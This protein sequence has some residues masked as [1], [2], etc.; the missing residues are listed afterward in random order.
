MSGS[1][2]SLRAAISLLVIV[3]LVATAKPVAAAETDPPFTTATPSGTLGSNGWYRASP[4]TVA[5]AAIDNGSGVDTTYR[6]IGANPFVAGNAISVTTDGTNVVQYYSTDR[7]GNVETTRSLTVR[8][9]TR[10]P[11]AI[12]TNPPGAVIDPASPTVRRYS[13]GVSIAVSYQDFPGGSG[14]SNRSYFLT[15]DG[16]VGAWTAYTDPV[17]VSGEGTY[18]FTAVAIDVAGREGRA[19]LQFAIDTTPPAL[20]LAAIPAVAAGAMPLRLAASETLAAS[21]APSADLDGPGCAPCTVTFERATKFTWVAVFEA[22]AAGTYAVDV[23]AK[24]ITGNAGTLS[25]TLVAAPTGPADTGL[26]P[27]PGSILAARPASV[28]ATFATPVVARAVL[29]DGGFGLLTTAP[30]ATTATATL[31]HQGP[32]PHVA[33]LSVVDGA[34]AR[35]VATNYLVAPQAPMLSGLGVPD[36]VPANA[37][38]RAYVNASAEGAGLASVTIAGAPARWLRDTLWVADVGPVAEGATIEFDV[39]AT[40]LAGVTAIL[41]GPVRTAGAPGAGVAPGVEPGALAWDGRHLRANGASGPTGAGALDGRALVAPEGGAAAWVTGVATANGGRT[42]V[43]FDLDAFGP[44]LLRVR[45]LWINDT[46]A[47]LAAVFAPFTVLRAATTAPT[48]VD[49]TLPA[50]ATQGLVRVTANVSGA[51][52]ARLVWNLTDP[53]AGAPADARF[54]EPSTVSSAGGILSV[55]FDL[56]LTPGLLWARLEAH[57]ARNGRLLTPAKA[58]HV[59]DSQAPALFAPQPASGRIVD[60]KRPVIGLSWADPSGV[61][62]ASVVVQVNGQT[63]PATS[64]TL[65]GGGFTHV[66]AA[67]LDGSV[68]VSVDVKDAFGRLAHFDWTFT[69]GNAP[70]STTNLGLPAPC[71]AQDQVGTGSEVSCPGAAGSDATNTTGGAFETEPPAILAHGPVG[72]VRDAAPSLTLRYRDAASAIPATGVL[73]DLDGRRIAV[74]ATNESA[75]AT[76]AGL[77]P[78]PHRLEATVDDARGNRARLAWTFWYAPPGAAFDAAGGALTVPGVGVLDPRGAGNATVVVETRDGAL[79]LA[80]FADGGLA[81]VRVVSAEPFLLGPK[82]LVAGADLALPAIVRGNAAAPTLAFETPSPIAGSLRARVTGHGLAPLEV[83]VALVG[84]PSNWPTG[85]GIAVVGVDG[86]ATVY[87]VDLK[88]LPEGAWIALATVHDAWGRAA[89]A[90]ATFAWDETRPVASFSYKP[91]A[92]A[93]DVLARDAGGIRSVRLL[94]N[95]VERVN[96]TFDARENGSRVVTVPLEGPLP[97][98]NH[99]VVVETTDFAGNLARTEG[100]IDL[101]ASVDVPTQ[102]IPAPSLLAIVSLLGVAALL[103]RRR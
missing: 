16:V 21:P 81:S 85:P 87:D 7:D 14:I 69:V 6:R 56:Q 93:F 72:V 13:A 50:S 32:G 99:S 2:R 61:D 102:R 33:G 63:V 9:D 65:T 15:K 94:L 98:G 43:V 34:H 5:F 66:P 11:R 29:L 71:A 51:D 37:R 18:T 59:T 90:N 39:Q 74:S 12:I 76:L 49:L 77:A 40:T 73:V 58:L 83:R 25:T 48:L 52:R 38:V 100:W 27:A 80:G 26:T 3:G 47:D 44:G 31:G 88:G 54:A 42:D 79:H 67:D 95:G 36:A 75:T 30:A 4:V 91:G 20:S 96:A 41:D 28:T 78:G 17:A 23:E 92:T 10:D 24:D 57:D 97:P 45:A 35:T 60:V 103:A 8:L 68:T 1:E 84:A 101:P 22:P 19:S 89:R 55:T 64:L 62:V 46:A 86:G 82:P 53:L 70:G